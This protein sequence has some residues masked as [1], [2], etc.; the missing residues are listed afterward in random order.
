MDSDTPTGFSGG[1]VDTFLKKIAADRDRELLA[2]AME[3]KQD[4]SLIRR[5]AYA[6]SRHFFR[7]QASQAREQKQYSYQRSLSRARTAVRR[8]RWQLLLQLQA[9]VMAGVQKHLEQAWQDPQAQSAWCKYW[10]QAAIDHAK[11]APLSITLGAGSLAATQTLIKTLTAK[12][13]APSIVSR[14][15]GQTPGI[16]I[17]WNGTLLDGSLT[18]QLVQIEDFVFAELNTWLHRD[19]L[20][21]DE[22]H[23]VHG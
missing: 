1:H 18:R 13:P 17:E 14:S 3:L 20:N 6:K 16:I 23:H 21:H 9:Q 10:L 7:Q 2:I 5:E 12:H 22:E 11:G 4:L 15:E 19:Q 8:K